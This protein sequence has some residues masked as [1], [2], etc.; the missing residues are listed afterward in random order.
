ML[1]CIERSQTIPV[2]VA[3]LAGSTPYEVTYY[4]VLFAVSTLA[5]LPPVLIA[6]LFQKYL[7]QGLL[8]GSVKG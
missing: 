2:I 7:I 3:G 8:S 5:I 1:P 4:G 6:F